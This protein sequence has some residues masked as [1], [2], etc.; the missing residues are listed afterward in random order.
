M[1]IRYDIT[2]QMKKYD[3]IGQ[4]WLPYIMYFNAPNY[5]SDVVNTDARGFRLVCR[6]SRVVANFRGDDKAPVCLLVGGST[7]FGVGASTDQK[8]IPSILSSTTGRLWLNFGGRA[9]SSTQ[10][11]IL[12][13]LNRHYLGK[14]SRI[15]IF[16]GLNNL[17]LHCCLSPDHPK[18]I[19]TFFFWNKY[20]KAMN[21][22]VRRPMKEAALSIM[23]KVVRTMRPDS[24]GK[25]YDGDPGHLLAIMERD[26]SNW[27]LVASG[28]GVEVYYVLQPM[29]H[30]IRRDY[31]KEEKALFSELDSMRDGQWKMFRERLN[32]EKYR[33]FSQNVREICQRQGVPFCDMN[34]E[35]SNRNLDGR[36]LFVDR[37]H[38]TDEG[39]AIVS[40]I[41]KEKKIAYE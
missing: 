25:I 3:G 9:Y 40:D 8:T 41:L 34:E 10:E 29:A 18:E 7:V 2:P 15:V 4:V 1:T 35:L 5:S 28:L 14:I 17:A 38:L 30:W 31:S 37:A 12:F 21:E 20:N 32:Y 39:N 24:A 23:R 13:M 22:T 26:I 11:F 33:W 36:W 6:G 19:G 16:S 27:K